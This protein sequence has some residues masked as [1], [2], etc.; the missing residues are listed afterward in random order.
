MAKAIPQWL[1]ENITHLET[2]ITRFEKELE[3]FRVVAEKYATQGEET[4]ADKAPADVICDSMADILEQRGA[5]IHRKEM[6]QQLVA[7][8]IHIGGKDPINN[9]GAYLSK[10]G[11]FLSVGKGRWGL[12]KWKG[13]KAPQPTTQQPADNA[14][15]GVNGHNHAHNNSGMKNELA[16]SANYQ[17]E[18]QPSFN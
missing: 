16:Q 9:V 2:E 12:K 8:S 15:N 10:D 7:R 4:A 17:A 13:D 6:L 1:Q 11:R 5:A 18:K 3:A 14:T